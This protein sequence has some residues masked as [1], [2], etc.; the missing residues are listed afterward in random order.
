MLSAILQLLRGFS[1]VYEK[2]DTA[3]LIVSHH[4]QPRPPALPT[5]TT[6]RPLSPSVGIHGD[7]SSFCGSFS[8]LSRAPDKQQWRQWQQAEAAQSRRQQSQLEAEEDKE[9]KEHHRR[10]FRGGLAIRYRSTARITEI[11]SRYPR[12]RRSYRDARRPAS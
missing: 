5:K 12:R 2:P 7:C 6:T 10:V 3:L 8:P 1:I 4:R 9:R 11:R